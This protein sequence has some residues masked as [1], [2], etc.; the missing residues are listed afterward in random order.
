MSFFATKQT[1]EIPID[2]NNR[3]WVKAKMDL[4][5]RSEVE[6]DLIEARMR[7]AGGGGG[8]EVSLRISKTAQSLALLKYNIVKWRGDGFTDETGKLMPCRPDTIELLDPDE[9]PWVEMVAAKIDELNQGKVVDV[10]P[11][12]LAADPN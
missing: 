5:T 11:E 8:G 4:K 6:R 2:N 12:K 10:D 1:I 7:S 9:C 3:V